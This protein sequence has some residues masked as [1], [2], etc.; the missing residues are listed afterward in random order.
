MLLAIM[1]PAKRDAAIREVHGQ[2]ELPHRL[3]LGDSHAVAFERLSKEHG[4]IYISVRPR[5]FWIIECNAGKI[6]ALGQYGVGLLQYE[7]YDSDPAA[8][9][10]TVCGGDEHC[11]RSR[12]FILLVP[13]WHRCTKTTVKHPRN[14]VAEYDATTRRLMYQE[15]MQWDLGTD[16]LDAYQRDEF[17]SGK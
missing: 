5:A 6:R 3:F 11:S 9:I 8:F 16:F 10:G 14:A 4:C 7:E 12:R 15:W 17:W 1:P 2:V 13:G